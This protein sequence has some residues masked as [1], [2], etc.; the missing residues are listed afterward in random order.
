MICLC[1]I[2]SKMKTKEYFILRTKVLS[3]HFID[4]ETEFQNVGVYYH[5]KASC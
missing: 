1:N 2:Q 4:K 5:Y 3:P